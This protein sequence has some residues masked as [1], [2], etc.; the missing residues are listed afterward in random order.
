MK[1]SKMS[2]QSNKEW[3]LKIQQD[4]NMY[5]VQ[6]QQQQRRHRKQPACPYQQLMSSKYRSPYQI[7]P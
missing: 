3:E 6:F 5:K 7:D 1:I 2:F 4:K